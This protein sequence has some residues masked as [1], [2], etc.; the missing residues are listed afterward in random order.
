MVG[1]FS[2][3]D[4]PRDCKQLKEEDEEEIRF[5]LV[6]YNP[7]L[8]KLIFTWDVNTGGCPSSPSGRPPSC[9]LRDSSRS[10]IFSKPS[11]PFGCCVCSIRLAL[12]V[13]YYYLLMSMKYFIFAPLY[14][15]NL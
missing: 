7:A 3:I 5:T 13:I 15:M 2:T 6:L 14:I 8:S 12:P 1:D 10:W 11:A 4:D 9:R